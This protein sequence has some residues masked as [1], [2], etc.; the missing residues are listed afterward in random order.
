[1]AQVVELQSFKAFLNVILFSIQVIIIP[2]DQ[3]THTN[4]KNSS[5]SLNYSLH[6]DILSTPQKS[7]STRQN[8]PQASPEGQYF[9]YE[10]EEEQ[11]YYQQVPQSGGIQNH[12]D[13][14]MALK[15]PVVSM[16][17]EA[18]DFLE[19]DSDERRRDNRLN[20]HEAQG[21]KVKYNGSSRLHNSVAS[22]FS[23]GSLHR[24]G[25]FFEEEF[26]VKERNRCE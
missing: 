25:R 13:E 26:V 17:S 1:M 2:L 8:V 18:K 12:Y 7:E 19:Q 24:E 5:L 3:H 21:P 15:A 16:V 9:E 20:Y 11:N 22:G 4:T 10:E 14:P 23:A 6:Q